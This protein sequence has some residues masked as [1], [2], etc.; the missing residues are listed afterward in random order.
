[1]RALVLAVVASVSLLTAAVATSAKSAEGSVDPAVVQRALD[2]LNG[3]RDMTARFVQR[4]LSG[5]HWTG[6]MWVSRPGRLRF[7]YDPPENDVIWSTG[8]LINHF[9]AELET[10]SHAPRSLTPAWFLL[11]DNV[12]ITE[13]VEVLATAEEKGR[14]FVTATRTDRAADGRVTLAFQLS[15]ARL[16]GWTTTAGDGQISQVDLIDLAVG[17]DIPDAIF[18]YKPPIPDYDTK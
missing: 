11:D 5:G 18:A 1:M 3:A 10:V 9:D 13:D 7:E 15:P 17:V 12:R 6:R 16:L 4:D 2:Y 8:G 14:Y